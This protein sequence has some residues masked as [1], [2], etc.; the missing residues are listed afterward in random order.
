[1]LMEVAPLLEKMRAIASMDL[2]GLAA[3]NARLA[4]E[5]PEL[6]TG[7]GGLA[8]L[9]LPELIKV[10]TRLLA[11]LPLILQGISEI[12]KTSVVVAQRFTSF[13]IGEMNINAVMKDLST[14]PTILE[15][16]QQMRSEGSPT[17]TG[18]RLSDGALQQ[19]ADQPSAS[20]QGARIASFTVCGVAL[21]CLVVGILQFRGTYFGASL[22]IGGGLLAYEAGYV[23]LSVRKEKRS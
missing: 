10:N 14:L 17:T 22:S 12:E 9:D 1:M 7:I 6:I 20:S 21:V 11:Q 4:E 16:L 8:K 23:L 19:V 13:Q 18:A 15:V 3:T 2:P 5:L